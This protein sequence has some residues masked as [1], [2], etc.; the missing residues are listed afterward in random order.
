MVQ[1]VD[2][3]F[4]FV[5]HEPNIYES[6]TYKKC[7]LLATCRAI[8]FAYD[9]IIIPSSE[10]FLWFVSQSFNPR[11]YWA[12]PW[13]PV[14]SWLFR[15]VTPA[16]RCRPYLEGQPGRAARAV[17]LGGEIGWWHRVLEVNHRK[18]HRMLNVRY[19]YLHWSHTNQP[20]VGEY[21]VHGSHGYCYV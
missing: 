4:V 15:H 10:Y 16:A 12:K 11:S 13:D 9:H 17:Y 3:C 8:K 7:T 21:T 14:Q 2:F 18:T 19:I 6:N 1:A 5:G 20:N